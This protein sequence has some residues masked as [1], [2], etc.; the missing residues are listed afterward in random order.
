MLGLIPV[1]ASGS[2][3]KLDVPDSGLRS[4][5]SGYDINI[6]VPYFRK[7][8]SQL[9]DLT[10]LQVVLTWRLRIWEGKIK[11]LGGFRV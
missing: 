6:R 4:Y 9:Q 10:V 2:F 11:N 7:L 1:Y 5:Y 8:S 3:R